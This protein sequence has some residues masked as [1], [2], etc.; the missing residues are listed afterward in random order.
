MSSNENTALITL[1]TPQLTGNKAGAVGS[2]A[3]EGDHEPEDEEE[4]HA[5]DGGT[6][7]TGE[8]GQHH[9]E[10][11][12][13][14]TTVPAVDHRTHTVTHREQLDRTAGEL[15]TQSHTGSSQTG[16]LAS[17]SQQTGT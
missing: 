10:E 8:E 15:H 12:R 6:A 9:T 4:L 13:R 3:T 5:V 14:P 2:D 1:R 16:Q 11:Q 17:C 7:V